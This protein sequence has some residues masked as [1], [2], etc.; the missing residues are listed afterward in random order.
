VAGVTFD[1]AGIL[2]GTTEFGG[3]ENQDGYGTIFKLPPSGG[4]WSE[5][6]LHRFSTGGGCE[7]GL[8]ADGVGF[9]VGP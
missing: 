6:V 1:C 9:E 4:T 8:Q 5:A 7:Q 3:I 2:Y